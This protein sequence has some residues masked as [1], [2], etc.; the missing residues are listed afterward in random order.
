MRNNLARI[1][2]EKVEVKPKSKETILARNPKM[3][4][5]H[6]RLLRLHHLTDRLTAAL[7]PIMS[8]NTKPNFLSP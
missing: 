1:N 4:T 2:L 3:T 8:Q 7:H 6:Q 5:I